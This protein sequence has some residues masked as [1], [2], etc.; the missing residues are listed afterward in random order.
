MYT[1]AHSPRIAGGIDSTRDP[2]NRGPGK[3]R[4]LHCFCLCLWNEVF[5]GFGRW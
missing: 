4:G 1:F 3:G 5:V 2:R